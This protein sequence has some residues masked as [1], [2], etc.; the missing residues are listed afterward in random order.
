MMNTRIVATVA[1]WSLVFFCSSDWSSLVDWWLIDNWGCLRCVIESSLN[2]LGNSATETE[3]MGAWARGRTLICCEWF[4]LFLWLFDRLYWWWL[5]PIYPSH[6]GHDSVTR[7]SGNDTFHYSDCLTRL[8]T[9][10]L[11]HQWAPYHMCLTLKLFVDSSGGVGRSRS[12]CGY[13]D[14]SWYES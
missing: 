2:P 13:S 4:C 7:G 6:E 3:V 5:T 11:A 14:Y 10:K 1:Y 12:I 8:R 9:I